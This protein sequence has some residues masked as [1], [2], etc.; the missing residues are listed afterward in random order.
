MAE[1]QNTSFSRRPALASNT[2]PL[3]VYGYPSPANAFPYANNNQRKNSWCG[4][5]CCL[6]WFIGIILTLAVLFVIAVVAFCLITRPEL[7]YFA[8]DSIAVNGMNLTSSS[9]ISPAVDV[10]IRA[11]N[12]NNKIGIYYEKHSTAEIFYRDVCLCNGA[13]PAFYQPTNNVTVFQTVL[14]GNGTKL[15]ERDRRALVNAV[16]KWSVP[17]TLKMRAPVKVKVG[18]VRTW[19]IG[20]FVFDCDVI[21]DQLTAQAKIVD[22]DCS[23]GLHH[24]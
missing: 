18:L 9:V 2:V 8:I 16:A 10:F 5:C 13:L 14:K 3:P 24:S 20:D 17:L 23:Y 12:G 4:R 21:V 1:S 11:D 15:A 19:K 7:P 22:T 6:W